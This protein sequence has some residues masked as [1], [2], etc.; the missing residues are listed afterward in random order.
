MSFFGFIFL[1]STSF[2]SKPRN[3]CQLARSALFFYSRHSSFCYTLAAVDIIWARRSWLG[4]QG[5]VILSTTNTE[6][7]WSDLFSVVHFIPTTNSSYHFLRY[8]FFHPLFVSFSWTSSWWRAGHSG[9]PYFFNSKNSSLIL[10]SQAIFIRILKPAL[11]LS[12]LK[13]RALVD[14]ISFV[15][16]FH[17]NGSNQPSVLSQRRESP[18]FPSWDTV[19]GQDPR[20]QANWS[21]R[22]EE[23]IWVCSAL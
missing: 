22:Q 19:R 23:S 18:V 21:R 11:V 13:Q 9:N 2:I 12:L 5:S 16:V 8:L 4:Y 1:C 6:F 3:S 15:V 7:A 17:Q 10:I 20:C 14:Y